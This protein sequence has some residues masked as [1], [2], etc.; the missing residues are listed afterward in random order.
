MR[1]FISAYG[2]YVYMQALWTFIVVAGTEL[3][4]IK[5]EWAHAVDNGAAACKK[6]G[7]SYKEIYTCVNILYKYMKY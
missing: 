7:I 1:V 2:A 6:H 4:T 5:D 3:S